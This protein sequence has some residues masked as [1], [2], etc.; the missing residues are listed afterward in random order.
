MTLD[1]FDDLFRQHGD[2]LL[3]TARRLLARIHCRQDGEDAVSQLYLRLL[4]QAEQI[5]LASASRYVFRALRNL[6]FD[7]GR[8]QARQPEPLGDE[9]AGLLAAP[10]SDDGSESVNVAE[11][12]AA[13][14]GALAELTARE[15]QA[16]RLSLDDDRTAAMGQMQGYDAALTRAKRKLRSL[17][18]SLEVFAVRLGID[19]IRE[20]LSEPPEV[21]EAGSESSG[22]EP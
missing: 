19:R 15:R 14:R 9:M 1:E 16:V 11:S 4:P 5:E 3:S 7:L 10:D 6:V 8:A 12:E 22:G 13:L 2:A 17:P 21:P 18:G 20:L